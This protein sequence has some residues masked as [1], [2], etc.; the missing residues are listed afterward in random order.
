MTKRQ[1]VLVLTMY[2]F[3]LGS[4][5]YYRGS[6]DGVTKY[7]HSKNMALTLESQYRFGFNDGLASRKYCLNDIGQ[8]IN[9]DGQCWE[10]TGWD[11]CK[12]H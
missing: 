2:S 5:L 7:K 10:A 11:P 8:W 12:F 6:K 1:A 3:I 9:D 4:Y